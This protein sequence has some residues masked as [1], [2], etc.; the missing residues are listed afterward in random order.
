MEEL[1]LV[2]SFD[3][4]G[5][6]SSVRKQVRSQIKLL[7]DELFKQISGLRI[8]IIIHNDYCDPDLVQKLDLTTDKQSI[9]DF[10]GRGSSNGG[11]DSKEAYAYVLNEVKSFKWAAANRLLIMIGDALPHEKGARSGG[12]MEYNDWRERSREL[13]D[14]NI[15]IYAIQALGDRSSVPF[16]EGMAKLSKGIK[17]DLSQFAHITDYI[18]AISHKQTGTLDEFQNSRVEY[19]TNS[20]FKNM[21]SKL[22]GILDEAAEAEML[23][24]G[25]LMGKFQVVDVPYSVRIMDFV[26]NMGLHYQRGKGYYQFVTS[27][28]IQ[29][30]KEVL[31]VDKS[32]GET[33]MDTNW[34]RNEMGLP[35]GKSGTLSPR[36][37]PCS[38]KYDI[39]I[40][41]NSYTRNLDPGTKFLYELDHK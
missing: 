2:I 40:Q 18:L 39:F 1:D 3:D 28:K 19:S 26:N 38:R 25:E 29:G 9:I 33:I 7:V 30:N 15:P 31:F 24:K 14:M 10:I 34:C 35:Y 4:T 8:G 20:A 13:G 36:S 21:F 22:R 37:V 16:Y 41:S 12:R 5:S 32:T 11:G 17:L 27:E 6:M 23:S